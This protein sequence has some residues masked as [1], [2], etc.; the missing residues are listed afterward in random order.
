MSKY[1]DDFETTMKDVKAIRQATNKMIGKGGKLVLEKFH[2][3]SSLERLKKI[4]REV[5]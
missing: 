1:S 4:I 3:V 2:E 5:N